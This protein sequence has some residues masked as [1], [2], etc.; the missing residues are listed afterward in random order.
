[1]VIYPRLFSLS[2]SNVKYNRTFLF[3]NQRKQRVEVVEGGYD[4]EPYSER[5]VC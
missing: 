1:M 5:L 4:L 2:K 3:F